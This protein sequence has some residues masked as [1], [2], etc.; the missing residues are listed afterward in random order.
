S[1]VAFN[2]AFDAAVQ[3]EGEFR[4]AYTFRSAEGQK[5]LEELMLLWHL[6]AAYQLNLETFTA[7]ARLARGLDYYTGPVFEIQL[8]GGAGSLG[9]GGRYDGLI[10][11]FAK[12]DIPAVGFSIG[13]E[14]LAQVLAERELYPEGIEY[15]SE[16]LVTLFSEETALDNVSL[17]QEIRDTRLRVETYPVP[18][19][20]AKQFKYASKKE[21][22]YVVVQGPDEVAGD[23]VKVKDMKAGVEHPISYEDLLDWL[24][25]QVN[26]PP[27]QNGGQIRRRK[28]P[29]GPSGGSPSKMED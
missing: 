8:E 21:I 9:G 27:P 4:V 23:T 29:R 3:T 22:P 1:I 11:M 10:G 17:A 24:V 16:V 19:N 7:D 12:Q 6:L 26:P 18:G 5:G 25:D 15:G 2:T 20:L 28:P 14:R 13:F